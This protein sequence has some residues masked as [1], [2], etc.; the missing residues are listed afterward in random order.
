M[1]V[2]RKEV[3]G[4]CYDH[5]KLNLA[6]HTLII[7]IHCCSIQRQT[8]KTRHSLRILKYRQICSLASTSLF[9]CLQPVHVCLLCSGR[10]ELLAAAVPL[11]DAVKTCGV[12]VSRG[13]YASAISPPEATALKQAREVF[14]AGPGSIYAS[15]ERKRSPSLRCKTPRDAALMLLTASRPPN[16][17][18]HFPNAAL[19]DDG[20][21]RSLATNTKRCIGRID[22]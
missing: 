2:T 10:S 21:L 13:V 20:T 12:K 5:L 3:N 1:V 11:R 7:Q 4:I 14:G 22:S 9:N 18:I 8:N 15:L 6:V 17:S 19:W 16:V